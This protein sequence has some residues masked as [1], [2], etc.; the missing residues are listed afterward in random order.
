MKVTDAK[1]KIVRPRIIGWRFDWDNFIAIAAIAA[2][3][4]LP[5]LLHS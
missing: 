5:L 2:L 1:F 4:A 3:S